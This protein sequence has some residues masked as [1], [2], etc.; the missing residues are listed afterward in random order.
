[1]RRGGW[2]T[3]YAAR[4]IDSSEIVAERTVMDHK[5]V[6]YWGIVLL[7]MAH[8]ARE[9]G[10][11]V[12]AELMTTAAM[13]Y[14]EEADCLAARWR[15]FPRTFDL[16]GHQPTNLKALNAALGL[17]LKALNAALHSWRD[18]TSTG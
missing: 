16:K 18:L 9:D 6:E 12:N 3:H 10:D 2:N 15:K 1:M 8:D 14:F 4:F 5:G 17:N 11:L 7:E 13:R